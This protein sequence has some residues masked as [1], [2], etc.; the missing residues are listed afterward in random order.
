MKTLIELYDERPIENVLASEVFRPERAIFLSPTKVAQ[1]KTVKNKMIQ[2]FRHCGLNTELVFL[3]TSLYDTDKVAKQ[4]KKV[5]ND[6]PDCVVDITGG[7]DAALFACG[8]V[9]MELNVPV[10]TYS[11]RK[12]SFFNIHHA[13]FADNFPCRVKHSVEECFMMA[14]GAF[15]T[16]RVDNSILG[17]YLDMIGPFFKIYMKH[18]TE[19]IRAVSYIQKA[20]Q[21]GKDGKVNLKVSANKTLSG[22][23]GS[24]L[25]APEKLLGELENIGMLK[26][27]KIT[28]NAVNFSF[29]DKQ[30]RNW[31]RDIG[32]VLELKVY[33]TCLDLQLFNDVCTSAIVDWE[34][35]FSSDS[36]TNEI[37]VM[38]M[39]GIFPVFIS[40]KTS[41]VNTEA[42]NE[43]A[44]LRDRFGG[45]GSRAMIV[46][47]QRCRSITRH[48]AFELDIGVID[49]DDLKAGRLDENIR[50]LMALERE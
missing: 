35:E 44:I 8:D 21:P 46:T 31:L 10:F 24:K 14:G 4:L 15:K 26:G 45:K 30:V 40:C 29:K 2:Y 50:A 48:R 32:S 37:D 39:H 38:A 17:K 5:L 12:N 19:W 9:C 23:R 41:T 49:L 43:L 22:S 16:G 33:K 47:T 11:R 27:L 6:Y 1:S 3:E 18:R 28:E 7:T 25:K 20:S 34:A 36:V 13:E 42:L